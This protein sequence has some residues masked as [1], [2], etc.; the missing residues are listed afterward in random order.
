MAEAGV[1]VAVLETGLGGR[2]DAVT[3]CEPCATAI[4]S[5]GLD[6]TEL[7][8]R[9][10]GGDRAREGR[11]PQAGRAVLR[12]A[13]AAPRPTT[14]S[15]ARRDG[16]RR[17]AVPAGA[18]L[19]PAAVPGRARGR[20]PDAT[21]PRSRSQ[22]ARAAAGTLGRPIDDGRWRG[23]WRASAGRAAA[24]GWGT[25]CCST[26][27][28]TSTARGR[29]PR[30]C[31]ALAPGRRVVL[32]VSIVERQGSGRRCWRR[33]RRSPA[34][35]WPRAPT[36]RARCRPRRWRRPPARSVADVVAVRRPGRRARR[37]APPRRP[38]RPGRRVR[39]DVPGRDAARAR[40]GRAGRPGPDVRSCSADVDLVDV[41]RSRYPVDENACRL[42][43]SADVEPATAVTVAVPV[44]HMFV[45]GRIGNAG[46]K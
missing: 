11:H 46:V 9:H 29:W 12:R 4:T 6:H 42:S 39:L 44:F 20:A 7:P 43:A 10:A 40:A 15:R 13:A 16:R 21:T 26:A 1:E 25:T 38:G 18:G 32:L 2:L 17:A 41:D 14:R 37:G 31:P 45:T 8:R 30:R 5:I 27:R 36:T 23:R 33:W 19:R 28:T 24:S 22:L 3:T 35:S 34:P